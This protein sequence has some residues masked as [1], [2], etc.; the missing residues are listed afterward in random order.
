MVLWFPKKKSCCFFLFFFLSVH[1]FWTLHPD[2]C[3]S[4][5]S[6]VMTASPSALGTCYSFL[7]CALSVGTCV[8]SSAWLSWAVTA[9]SS[10]VTSPGVAESQGIHH[11]TPRFV[12]SFLGKLFLSPLPPATLGSEVPISPHT[13][14][15]KVLSHV[16]PIW[17]WRK[18]VSPRFNVH[19]FDFFWWSCASPYM[20]NKILLWITYS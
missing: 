13:H 17:H 14:R 4:G 11:F 1:S 6:L 5:L 3:T 15:H 16:L 12:R 8:P 19:F 9:L 7:F 10:S 18:V 20:F 2:A